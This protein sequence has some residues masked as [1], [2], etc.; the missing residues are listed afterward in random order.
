MRLPGGTVFAISVSFGSRSIDFAGVALADSTGAVS[1]SSFEQLSPRAASDTS[2]RIVR[3]MSR[4]R[5]GNANK[6]ADL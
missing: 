1:P 3:L 2:S 5:F 4:L 6:L